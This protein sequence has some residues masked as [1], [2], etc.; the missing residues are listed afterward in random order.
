MPIAIAA[1]PQLR[2]TPPKLTADSALPDCFYRGCDHRCPLSR[3]RA[4]VGVIFR[5]ALDRTQP[6]AHEPGVAIHSGRPLGR[7]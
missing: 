5:A 4:A 6:V 2:G 7:E 3:E 1:F